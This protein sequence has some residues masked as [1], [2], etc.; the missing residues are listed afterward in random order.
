EGNTKMR[1]DSGIMYSDSPD[2][3]RLTA[4]Q[5]AVHKVQPKLSFN[6]KHLPRLITFGGGPV[7]Q[8]RV[9]NV[10]QY[11]QAIDDDGN[12]GAPGEPIHI[13][14][15]L[16]IAK[17]TPHKLNAGSETA[18]ASLDYVATLIWPDQ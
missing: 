8:V 17:I 6:C 14:I 15:N 13:K 5:G 1:Y 9:A 2:A 10:V 4:R 18:D 11:L 12:D 3:G 16:P 7:K